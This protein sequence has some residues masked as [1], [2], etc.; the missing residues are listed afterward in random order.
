VE[1][2]IRFLGG[3]DQIKVPDLYRKQTLKLWYDQIISQAPSAELRLG[4]VDKR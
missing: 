4:A 2:G 3:K 1:L